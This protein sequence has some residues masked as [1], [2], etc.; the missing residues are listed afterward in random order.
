MGTW[1]T[2][3]LDQTVGRIEQVLANP[4]GARFLPIGATIAWDNVT[5]QSGDTVL[6]DSTPVYDGEK[7][8]LRGTVMCRVTKS[9]V[10]TILRSSS[11]DAWTGGTFTIGMTKTDEYGNTVTGS[12]DALAYNA[13]AAVVQAALEDFYGP[14]RVTVAFSTNTWTLTFW[15]G[16]GNVTQVTAD[17]TNITSG[18][19]KA[20]TIATTTAGDADGNSWPPYNGSATDGTQTLTRGDV[21]ILNTTLKQANLTGGF[22]TYCDSKAAGLLIEGTVWKE[23]L[24]V[25]GSG[26][27]SLSALAAVMPGLRWA[28]GDR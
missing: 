1:G 16:L 18:G 25:D 12:T 9:E 6:A 5:A 17:I 22:Q 26:Q 14:G 4:Y 28:Y 8:I 3:A 7:A 20:V 15:S 21:A 19:T 2:T 24:Q 11:G 13:S 10:Q 27:P 23:R